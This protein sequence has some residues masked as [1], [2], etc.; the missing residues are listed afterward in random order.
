MHHSVLGGVIVAIVVTPPHC[1]PTRR[2]GCVGV[3]WQRWSVISSPLP[4][5]VPPTTHPTSSCLQGWGQ[6]ACHGNVAAL[7]V[8]CR[9]PPSPSPCLPLIFLHLLSSTY[10]PTIHPASS[11]SQARGWCWSCWSCRGGGGPGL[12]GLGGVSDVA[13]MQGLGGC[14]TCGYPPRGVSQ[15]PSGPS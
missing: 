14:L 1:R 3:T 4:I 12:Q 9:R 13:G 2:A 10:A 6:V 5:M 11:G 15:D 8:V 7:V